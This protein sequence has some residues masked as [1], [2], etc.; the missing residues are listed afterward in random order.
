MV[1]KVIQRAFLAWISLFWSSIFPLNGQSVNPGLPTIAHCQTIH[2]PGFTLGFNAQHKQAAWVM[3]SLNSTMPIGTE[4]RQNRFET[5]PMVKGGSADDNDYKGSGYDRGHLA[6]AQDM[7]YSE[8][9][10]LASF[11][12][13]NMSPQL[14]GFNRGIWKRAE[15][16]VRWW[17]ADKDTIYVVTGPIL[18]SGL[19]SIGY[20]QVSIPSFY[21]K[22]VFDGSAPDYG[23]IALLIPHKPSQ[24][25]I[26][27]F[28]VSVDSIEQLTG[29]NFFS[30]LPDSLENL[31]ESTVSIDS[32]VWGVS[33]PSKPK[34]NSTS[35]SMACQGVTKKGLPCQNRTTS[36]NGFCYLHQ[37]Q[38]APV[39]EKRK[40]AVQCSGTTKKGARCKNRTTNSSGRCYLHP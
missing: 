14:P 19:P 37:P 10:M 5:D 29:I 30:G 28:V 23:M 27:E 39:I 11:Y 25:S 32:W 36:T 40:E 35:T 18:R 13:S 8:K 12:Y 1:N 2:H 20:H 34:S 17:A 9:S 3:Y 33:S 26:K 38:S 7:S 31:F 16:Q 24:Q 21:Y 4:P 22:I 15:S 6:P